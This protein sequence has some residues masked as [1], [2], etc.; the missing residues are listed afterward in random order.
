MVLPTTKR[1]KNITSKKTTKN[2][3]AFLHIKH[4]SVYTLILFFSACILNLIFVFY[5]SIIY[6]D[7]SDTK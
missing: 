2:K 6:K 1:R 7:E 5:I 4:L 3:I